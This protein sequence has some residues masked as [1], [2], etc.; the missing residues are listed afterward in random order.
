MELSN[1]NIRN[2]LCI[3]LGS[4]IDSKFGT[5]INSL[6]ESK[7]RIEKIISNL[8]NFNLSNNLEENILKNSFNW[9]SLYQTCPLGV[10]G[11][12]PDYINCLLLVTGDLLP[13]SSIEGARFL[14]KEFQN[15][16]KEFGRNKSSE[17]QRW[18]PRPLD[19]DILWWD[20]LFINDDDFKI[21]H[22]RFKNRNFV[23][24]PLAEV[25]SSTQKIEKL[26]VKNWVLN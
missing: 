8:I 1:L 7:F 11:K 9:S 16:E 3:S 12:Q 18:L 23:I 20:D 2:G 13:S 5:P 15:L 22:P 14:L 17:E 26:N 4:N 25:L 6:I 19:I 21:P 10:I 24:S